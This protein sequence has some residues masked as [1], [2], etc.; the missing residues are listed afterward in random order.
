MLLAAADGT[1][2]AA[3]RVAAGSLAIAGLRQAPHL[4]AGQ[5]PGQRD[6]RQAGETSRTLASVRGHPR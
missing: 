6:T 3:A 2:G 4:I 5:V 1:G